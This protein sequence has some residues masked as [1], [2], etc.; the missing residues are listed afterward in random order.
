M[1]SI[2]IQGS[3]RS[4][5][6]T[7]KVAALLSESLD[8]ELVHL[9]D[10][11]IGHYEY[12]YRNKDDDFLPLMRRMADEFDLFVFATPVYWYS[13]SGKMKAFMDRLSDCIRIDKE[14]GRKLRGK[15]MAALSNSGD[16]TEYPSLFRAFELSAGYLGMNYN[17][18]LHT[19][20][21]RDEI[22]QEVVD[23]ITEF[24]EKLSN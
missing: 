21:N 10:L 22:P 9:A 11:D 12:D 8:A 17:G 20:V 16:Q 1:K 3:S 15:S 18:H 6:N 5:G 24:T 23:S 4:D 2:I 14:T 13:M 7:A 19:W